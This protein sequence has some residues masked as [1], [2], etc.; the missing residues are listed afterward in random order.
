VTWGSL[1]QVAS[2]VLVAFFT[3]AI[4]VVAVL[5]WRV[6][7]SQLRFALYGKRYELYEALQ[8]LIATVIRDYDVDDR[9]LDAYYRVVVESGFLFGSETVRYLHEAHS[10][11]TEL[12]RLQDQTRGWVKATIPQDELVAKQS[13]IFE[14]FRAEINGRAYQRFLPYLDFRKIK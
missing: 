9:D 10:K 12:S 11:A 6:Y 5:Q 7:N 13:E 1:L 4:A 14:W 8:K 2:A 3:V